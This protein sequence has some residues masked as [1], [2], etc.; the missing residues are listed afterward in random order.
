MDVG[1]V[2]KRPA[3]TCDPATTLEEAARLMRQ[4]N[5]GCLVVLHRGAM[6][7][8]V[9][10]R[11]LVTRGIAAD[12]GLSAPVEAL[13]STDVALAFESDDLESA[14]TLM[15]ARGLRRLPVLDVHS[16][17]QGVLSLDDL[18]P[19]FADQTQR[20]SVAVRAELHR[21]ALDVPS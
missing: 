13:M 2:C 15:A 4:H 19:V 9:T 12:T 21:G 5:V 1:S 6:V 7:G 18:V 11:D 14:A 20:L 8:V 3:V 17:V 16:A 10:D